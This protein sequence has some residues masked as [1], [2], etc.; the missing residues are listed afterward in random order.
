MTCATLCRY[1]A[2][3]VCHCAAALRAPF[4]RQAHIATLPH[5]RHACVPHALRSIPPQRC[6]PSSVFCWIPVNRQ[7][8]A[9]HA[10]PPA[11]PPPSILAH[12]A[13]RRAYHAAPLHA[14]A[15]KTLILACPSHSLRYL[16][17]A[18]NHCATCY[19]AACLVWRYRT[20]AHTPATASTAP[21]LHYLP[22]YSTRLPAR[23]PFRD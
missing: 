16:P 12:A 14:A 13:V 21:L 23:A 8:H 17:T 4:W 22:S 5:Y 9:T 11:A 18:F 20:H 3:N 2:H 1:L 6:A 15:C 19:I 10:P 7:R